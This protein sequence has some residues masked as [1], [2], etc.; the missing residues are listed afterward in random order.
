M[1]RLRVLLP[2]SSE[3][4]GCPGARWRRGG[5]ELSRHRSAGA[6]R[7]QA[8]SSG[9]RASGFGTKT[10]KGAKKAD[11]AAAPRREPAAPAPKRGGDAAAPGIRQEV[12]RAGDAGRQPGGAPQS[13]GEAL[14]EEKVFEERLAALRSET[15][16]KV[17]KRAATQVAETLGPID[18]DAID[19]KPAGDGS[20]PAG[21]A[22]ST[23]V[24]A[25]AG[26][27][28]VLTLAFTLEDIIPT[29]A[30]EKRAAEGGGALPEVV[31][32]RL[33]AQVDE[34]EA[35]L[36]AAPGDRAALEGAAVSSA[37]LGEYPKAADYLEKL[38]K[39]QPGDEEALRLLAE[40]RTGMQ[41]FR[42]AADAYRQA[43]KVAAG[44]RMELLTGLADA[45]I[46]DGKPGEAVSEI[47]AARS[48][49]RAASE[50]EADRKSVV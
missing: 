15:Q 27:F 12:R 39:G 4:L 25:G 7:S 35:A 17:K 40:V 14:L 13:S 38:L 8:T 26:L 23:A 32:K 34:N 1:S 43:R 11:S 30:P 46:A 49:L 48:R 22:S 20:A 37:E 3:A 9:K 24:K 36:R 33:Q 42:A 6:A 44:E 31:R 16:E 2:A 18:Y 45:L 41:Q 29:A 19:A 10:G 50:Q 47:L 5:S 28:V 21:W